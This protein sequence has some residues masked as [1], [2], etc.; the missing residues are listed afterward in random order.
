MVYSNN[1]PRL[2]NYSGVY[3]I[4]RSVGGGISTS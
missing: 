2:K 4:R 3:W 1:N